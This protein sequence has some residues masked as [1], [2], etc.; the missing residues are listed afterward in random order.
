M[1]P[2]LGRL[3]ALRRVLRGGMVHCGHGGFLD[4]GRRV[5]EYIERYLA[6]LLADG[7]VRI[8]Q[9]QEITGYLPVRV[10]SAGE[11]RYGELADSYQRRL[12][13]SRSRVGGGES[14]RTAAGR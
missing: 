6:A 1:S 2:D 5:P 4:H 10:T 9:P 8:G 7:H 14:P 11:A 12:H 3:L 13:A